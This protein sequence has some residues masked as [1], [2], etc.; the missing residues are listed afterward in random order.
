MRSRHWLVPLTLAALLATAA[1]AAAQ[2]MLA[3]PSFEIAGGAGQPFA[4]WNNF[5]PVASTTIAS[6]G[7]RAARLTGPNTGNWD[8]AG[9]W[10]PQT[11]SPGAIWDVAGVVR[12]PAASPLAGSSRAIVNV[13]WRDAGGNLIAYESHDVATATSPRDSNLAFAFASGA[14]PAGT[15]TTRLL[16]GV[17][18][19]PTDPARDA[20]YDEVTFVQRTTPSLDAKQWDDFPG[21]RTLSFSGRDWR[22]KGTGFYGPGPNSFSDSPAAVWVDGGGRLHL[23]IARVGATWFS[24]EVACTEPLGYGDYVFTT[25]GRLDTLHPSTVFGLFLWEYGPCYDP[26]YLWWNP[27]NEIDVEFS[28]WGV[29]GG[30]NA[31]FVAQPWDWGGNRQQFSVTFANDEVTSHAFRWL[32]DRVEFRSWRGDANAESPPTTI[33]AWTYTGPHVPR[34]DQP[35]VH[36]NLW[37]SSGPPTTT[38]EVVLDAFTF[39]PSSPALLD[40]PAADAGS[41]SSLALTLAGRHPATDGAALRLRLPRAGAVRLALFDAAGRRVRTLDPGVRP[42]GEH[43]LRWDGRDDAGVRVAPGV[44]LAAAEWDGRRA[45]ARVVVLR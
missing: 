29:P 3:N 25:R 44:Y 41:P 7:Q 32:P 24:T 40:A 36:L 20:I 27:Y 28:R 39:R 9:V 11:T 15:A 35:R 4:G 34:L 42:A 10:Q 18:Q 33:R 37:Q 1:P 14:A 17:L 16:L 2:C 5:G 6:H 26:G 19:G 43:V 8:V 12:V 38:Q 13:E 30:P 23:T 45:S 22:V 21:G 31:Q